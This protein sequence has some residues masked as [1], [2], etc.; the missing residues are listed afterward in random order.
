MLDKEEATS[1]QEQGRESGEASD[2]ETIPPVRNI[3]NHSADASSARS[4]SFI[5]CFVKS[6]RE[7]GAAVAH[8]APHDH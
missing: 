4:L 2:L 1:A 5:N 8:V 7:G 6:C 3:Y